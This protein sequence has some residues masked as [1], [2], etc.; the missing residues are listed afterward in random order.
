MV[1][2]NPFIWSGPVEDAVERTSF[3]TEV[4]LIL[5]G[6]THVALFGPRG[7]GKTTFAVGL[8]RELAL[9]HGDD[10]PTWEMLLVDLRHVISLGAFSGALEQALLEHPRLGRPARAAIAHWEA[11]LAVN[12]GVV[13]ARAR[14]RAGPTDELVALHARLRAL[15]ELC[16]RLVVVFDEF[17]R[18]HACPGEPLSVIRSALM[19]ADRTGR[20]SLILTGSLRGRLEMMLHDTR[21][22]IWDQTHDLDLPPLDYEQL[23]DYVSLKFAA[24]GKPIGEQAV[25]HLLALSASHPKRTQHLAWNVWQHTPGAVDRV[26]VQAAYDELLQSPRLNAEFDRTIDT[27][28]SG[29]EPDVNEVRALFLL[30]AGEPPGS[31]KSAQRYGLAHA[32][33]TSR[34]LERLDA[35]GLVIHRGGAWTI[36]DPLLAG[37]LRRSDRSLP[38]HRNP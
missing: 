15:G 10:A 4:A 3:A 7:T 35:R 31:D 22:P 11:E 17:Q 32:A 13:S 8:A 33:S 23:L 25:E 37:Y 24:T 34:A 38:P 6:G 16:A 2:V 18:L 9:E 21:E 12:L 5:K 27:L 20:V 28:L 19:S 36:V 26:D 29:A 1:A 14:R 30:A